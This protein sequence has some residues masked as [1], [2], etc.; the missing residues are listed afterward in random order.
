MDR[1]GNTEGPLAATMRLWPTE[2][3]APPDRPELARTEPVASEP[4]DPTR[5]RVSAV[6]VEGT[7]YCFHFDNSTQARDWFRSDDLRNMVPEVESAQ[8]KRPRDWRPTPPRFLPICGETD[9]DRTMR[10][11]RDWPDFGRWLTRSVRSVMEFDTLVEVVDH[12]EDPSEVSIN[13]CWDAIRATINEGEE[14]EAEDAQDEL[15]EALAAWI[16][17]ALG[18]AGVKLRPKTVPEHRCAFTVD[19]ITPWPTHGGV[20][21]VRANDRVKI[22]KAVNVN[23]RLSGLQTSSPFNLELVAVAPGGL[24]EEAAFHAQFA[25]HRLRG[26]WF[27]WCGPIARLVHS[28]RTKGT[29]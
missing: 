25:A 16:P 23:N 20:Y 13:G 4:E 18:K 1:P 8:V 19:P 9:I 6:D 28:L 15:E 11:I 10:E 14:E 17:I 22:G 24:A 12:Y 2:D 27:E 5:W 29:P 7:R 21:F 26:E 3:T